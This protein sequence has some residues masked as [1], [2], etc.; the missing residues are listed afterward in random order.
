[1]NKKSN[2]IKDYILY[3][4]L[5]KDERALIKP[6]V[7]KTNLKTWRI[8]SVFLEFLFFCL[9]VASFAYPKL[10]AYTPYFGALA[11]Y[12][13][14]FV[15]LILVAIDQNSKWLMPLLYLTISVLLSVLLVMSVFTETIVTTGVAFLAVLVCAST[16]VIDQPRRYSLL[17]LLFGILFCV[18]TV[19]EGVN[20]LNIATDAA[21]I[22][23]INETMYHDVILGAIFTIISIFISV[24][25]HIIRCSSLHALAQAE[26]ERD[27]DALT[28]VKNSIAY[29]H[30]I[31]EL[32]KMIQKKGDL[33]FAI[34]IFDINN[35]KQINDTYGHTYG[36]EL[37][38]KCSSL[39]C[40]TYVHSPVYRI[41]GDEFV[42]IV[43]NKDFENRDNLLIKIKEEVAAIHQIAKSPLDDCSIAVGMSTFSKQHDFEYLSVFSRA[44]ADMYENKRFIKSHK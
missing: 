8:I 19:I 18:L 7:N 32:N 44:D 30:E 12:M 21:E 43:T 26:K 6:L 27:I 14:L 42:V 22:Q 16:L 13:T 9:F 3:G 33:N 28:H 40:D 31:G 25:M 1:M 17:L 23:S 38:R 20:N 2:R 24:Y 41:G 39:I 10:L 5:S 35:L 15:V 4:G 37:I 36:D 29:E 34:V 11:A